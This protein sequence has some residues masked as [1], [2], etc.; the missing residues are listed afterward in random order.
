MNLGEPVPIILASGSPRRVN[1]MRSLGLEF[2][3]V[4]PREPSHPPRSENPVQLA[5]RLAAAKALQFR[6]RGLVVAADTLVVKGEK[7]YPKPSTRE[8]ALNLLR[9]LSGGVHEVITGVAVSCFDRLLLS[10]ERTVV[11]MRNFSEAEILTYVESGSPM[12][13]AGAYGIQDEFRPVQ[14]FEGCYQNVVGL[15]LCNLAKLL[16]V[17]VEVKPEPPRECVSCPRVR[18]LEGF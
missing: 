9:E 4:E 15:P 17:F 7:I 14:C 1:L 12:D 10:S 16:R 3:V 13:K 6:G 8:A 5:E 11:I 2:Q 18:E